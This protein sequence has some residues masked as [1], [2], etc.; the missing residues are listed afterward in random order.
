MECR[1]QVMSG[2]TQV[3]P[4]EDEELSE[5]AARLPS[6]WLTPLTRLACRLMI[7]GP[8]V[9]LEKRGVRGPDLTDRDQAG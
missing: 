5:M 7:T 6:R 8:G 3:A 2:E 4:P 9:V 1:V